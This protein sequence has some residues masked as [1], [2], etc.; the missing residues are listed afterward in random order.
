MVNKSRRG[1][2]TIS[3]LAGLNVQLVSALL[4]LV[5]LYTLVTLGAVFQMPLL[6]EESQNL[7]IHNGHRFIPPNILGKTENKEEYLETNESEHAVEE[8]GRGDPVKIEALRLHF[9]I[10][11]TDDDMEEINHPGQLYV[12]KDKS[13]PIEKMKVPKFWADSTEVNEAYGEGGVR[14]FLGN[15]GQKLMTLS[16]AKSVGSLWSDGKRKRETIYISVASYRDPECMPTIESILAR[17]KYPQRIRV[18]VIDQHDSEKDEAYCGPPKSC[19]GENSSSAYCLYKDQVDVYHIEARLSI[20]PVFARHV[21]HRMYRGEY[22][23]MQ[24]DSHIRFTQDWDDD[25]IWQWK[26]ARNEMAVLTTYLSDIIGSID[27]ETHKSK[28]PGRPIMCKSGYEG[29][30]KLKHLR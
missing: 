18:A 28:H 1:H 3:P 26:S 15:H 14:E 4:I 11:V 22:Y 23:A 20:G 8:S 2:R 24:V 10:M 16:E 19:D 5:F 29:Q 7:V 21:A 12:N 6:L 13:G 17:A 27:P 25:L 9:P 30:G